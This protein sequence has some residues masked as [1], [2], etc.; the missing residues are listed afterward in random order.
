MLHLLH[1]HPSPTCE[2]SLNWKA[3]DAIE[4]LTSGW[5]V[6]S[7]NATNSGDCTSVSASVKLSIHSVVECLFTLGKEETMV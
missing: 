4:L 6:F 2:T 3:T 1:P 7:I 5:M